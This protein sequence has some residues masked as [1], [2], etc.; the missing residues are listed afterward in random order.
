M[1]GFVANLF[2]LRAELTLYFT[3]YPNYRNVATPGRARNTHLRTQPDEVFKS[4]AGTAKRRA[5]PHDY[6]G[7]ISGRK[8]DSSCDK[9]A[10]SGQD[11]N[12]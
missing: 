5:C 1:K 7:W 11:R 12:F 6:S 4:T 3:H 10:T 8:C 9:Q 2:T